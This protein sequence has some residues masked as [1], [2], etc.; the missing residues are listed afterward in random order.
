MKNKY[1]LLM[2]GILLFSSVSAIPTGG[3]G[4]RY[5]CYNDNFCIGDYNICNQ[6]TGDCELNMTSFTGC[7]VKNCG[8][9]CGSRGF[10]FGEYYQEDECWCEKYKET[11]Y[12]KLILSD[13]WIQIKECILEGN[14]ENEENNYK[15]EENK[16]V[17]YFIFILILI[18]LLI[19]IFLITHSSWYRRKKIKRRVSKK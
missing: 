18:Y 5:Y 7:L 11:K 9:F 16:D 15:N 1:L 17:G 12:G 2:F 13:G 4:G 6:E 3:G 8:K 14:Y 19:I 10:D